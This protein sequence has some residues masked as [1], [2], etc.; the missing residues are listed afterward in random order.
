[1]IIA[2]NGDYVIINGTGFV[3]KVTQ[4]IPPIQTLPVVLTIDPS[5]KNASTIRVGGNITNS[6]GS[7]IIYRGICCSTSQNPT[8]LDISIN[9]G[10]N[11]GSWTS[12]LGSLTPDTSYYVKAWGINHTGIAYGS[13]KIIKTLPASGVLTILTT[14]ATN[15]RYVNMTFT[16]NV[17][18]DGGA[19]VFA[20]GILVSTDPNPTELNSTNLTAGTGGGQFTVSFNTYDS[21]TLYYYKAYAENYIGRQY[22]GTFSITSPLKTFASV[23]TLLPTNITTNSLRLNGYMND[24]GSNSVSS[25]GYLFGNHSGLDTINDIYGNL[26][27]WNFNYQ[28]STGSFP[29]F[30]VSGLNDGSTYYYNTFTINEFGTSLGVEASIATLAITVP[31]L[32]TNNTTNITYKEFTSGFTIIN[33]GGKSIISRGII[34][35]KTNNPPLINLDS[36]INEPLNYSSKS[37]IVSDISMNNIYHVRSYAVNELGIGYGQVVDVSVLNYIPAVIHSTSVSSITHN[38]AT[39]NSTTDSI[40]NGYGY[41]YR[42]GFAYS[43]SNSNPHMFVDTWYFEHDTTPLGTTATTI[44]GLTPSTSYYIRAAVSND[45]WAE[46]AEVLSFSTL[47][48]PLA[49]FVSSITVNDPSVYYIN[50]SATITSD[51]GFAVTSRGFYLYNETGTFIKSV[52]EGGAGT[53][54]YTTNITSLKPYTKYKIRAWAINSEGTG[55]GALSDIVIT[56]PYFGNI[57]TVAP[58][59]INNTWPYINVSFNV[60]QPGTLNMDSAVLLIGTSPGLTWGLAPA[61]RRFELNTYWPAP[62]G[63]GADSEG[64]YHEPGTRIE[65]FYGPDFFV[66]G[67]TYYLRMLKHKNYEDLNLDAIIYGNEISWVAVTS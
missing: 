32:S 56:Y 43:T 51:Q 35:S 16:G 38:S 24:I 30:Q 39:L 42:K 61:E 34:Y 18:S 45:Y 63:T 21:S 58:S 11:T 52:T 40:G 44:T 48:A 7:S 10:Y 50:V 33:D 4:T 15:V 1:M 57:I 54:L 67:N 27:P 46:A 2:K 53:G 55:V 47:A 37:Q 41:A 28:G 22:G 60:T 6:G 5:A 3:L 31:V 20:R 29:N 25:Y 9:N 59:F 66:P 8:I 12:E 64:K 49:P 26:G 62:R 13:E 65:Y 23:S 17:T 36:S 14:G 19:L